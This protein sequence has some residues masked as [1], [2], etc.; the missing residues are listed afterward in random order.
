[1]QFKYKRIAP[2]IIR[3]IISITL[4][5]KQNKPIG[6]EALVDSGADMCVFPAQIGELLG[7]K[8]K[9]GTSGSLSGVIG[10]S[11]KI[12]YHDIIVDIGGNS[13]QVN[14]VLPPFFHLSSTSSTLE[15]K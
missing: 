3:P 9:N 8:I 1:M 7:I 10:K 15:V 2:G 11:G 12:Y 4:R 13:T 14:A 6:Y 5:Y